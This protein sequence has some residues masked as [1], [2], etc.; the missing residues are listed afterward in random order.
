M[1]FLRLVWEKLKALVASP[2]VDA[3]F[4]D[5]IASHLDLAIED[6]MRRGLDAEQARREA[7]RR[8]GGIQRARELHRETRGLPLADAAVQDLSYAVRTLRRTPAFTFVVVASL[9]LGIGAN[10]AV[11]TLINA[12]LFRTLPVPEPQGLV[13]LSASPVLSFPMYEDLRARQQV[14]TDILSSSREW[15]VRLTMLDRP[16]SPTLDNVPTEFVSANYFNVLLVKPQTGRF[17]LEVEDRHPQS[18][19]A[20]GSV[21][22]I[23]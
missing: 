13:H 20:E 4:D 22:V 23:S 10:T 21:A 9:A 15:D 3:D 5:E 8:L 2:R 1:M 14:F 7:L 18:A 6:G 17:F 11:F 16:G 19:E 12:A